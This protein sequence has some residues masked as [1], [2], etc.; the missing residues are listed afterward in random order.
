MGSEFALRGLLWSGL[1]A[2]SLTLFTPAESA[3]AGA[4]SLLG[5]ILGLV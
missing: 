1:A 5:E 3:A 4:R 2:L